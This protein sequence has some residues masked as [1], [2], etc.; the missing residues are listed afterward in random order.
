MGGPCKAKQH[1]SKEEF[2]RRI[3]GG[4]TQ[5]QIA[6]SLGVAHQV[7]QYYRKKWGLAP[8]KAPVKAEHC[9]V[10]GCP[11]EVHGRGLCNLHFKRKAAHGDPTTIKIRER[12][13][14]TPHNGGYWRFKID[15]K[16][17]MRHRLIAQGKIGRELRT[18]EE[19][20]HLDED[21]SNDSPSNLIVCPN[22][23][24]H[25]AFHRKLRKE[26]SNGV[27]L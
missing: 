13:Q 6:Q 17:V 1:I 25:R 8:L 3:S 27:Q 18:G 9:V 5:K 11:N 12:G 23:A 2:V 15:G 14:G 24:A 7:L 10:P 20:H 4:E 26:V 22:R 21:K 19:V 16:F